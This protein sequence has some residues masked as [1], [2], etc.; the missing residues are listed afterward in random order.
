MMLGTSPNCEGKGV[1]EI[2][3]QAEKQKLQCTSCVSAYIGPYESGL[4]IA[5]NVA[6]INDEVFLNYFTG[7]YFDLPVDY[8]LPLEIAK[9]LGF[10]KGYTLEKGQYQ[11]K[12]SATD[13]ILIFK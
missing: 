1:C 2:K 7:E 6:E 4:M 9:R 12:E 5:I 13:V 8:P 3:V 11:F 10:P